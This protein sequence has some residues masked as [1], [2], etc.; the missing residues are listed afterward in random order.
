MPSPPDGNP[1][2]EAPADPAPSRAAGL[3]RSL[4]AAVDLMDLQGRGLALLLGLLAVAWLSAGIYKVQPDEQGVVLRFGRW[5]ETTGS[6]LHYHLP[7]PIET[8]LLPKVTQVN[9]L[10]LGTPRLVVG[11]DNSADTSHEHQMLTGDE[12][13]VEADCAVFVAHQGRRQVPVQ[14]HAPEATLKI[15]AESA[16]REIIS[17]TPI[18]AAM[19]DK[20]QQIAEQ[21]KDL[22]QTLLDKAIIPASWSRR[23]SCSASTRRPRSSTPSTTCSAPAPT[24]SAPATRPRPTPTTSSRVPAARRPH[25]PGAEGLQG[26]GGEP[27]ARARPRASSSVYAELRAGRGR[28]GLAAVSRER[29][30]GAEESHQGHHRFLRQGRL[31]HRAVHAARGEGQAASVPR[32]AAEMNRQAAGSLSRQ[33]VFACCGCCRRRCSRWARASRRWSCAS[34]AP[35]GVVTEPGPEIQAAADRHGHLLRPP[36]AAAGAAGRADHPRRPEAHRGA[37]LHA[38]P[39]RRSAA[40]LYQRCARWSRPAPA[41]A[42]RQLVAAPRARPGDAAVPAVRAAHAHRRDRPEGSGGQGPRRSAS[43]SSRCAST[44]PTCRS[45]PARPSMTA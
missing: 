13:I 35:I 28:H 17:R 18:Q 4:V 37:D 29:G 30:R 25:Y 41:R 32:E 12:N 23:C 44:A 2:D 15:A 8:V 10:Q 31:R 20:R 26:T 43:M 36:A 22:L 24:R 9:Q 3:A 21:T 1:P 5:V 42:D 14:D 19:S 38:L 39:H 16:M 7:Y 6:G 40:L 34:G 27:R 45:R 33:R 11:T